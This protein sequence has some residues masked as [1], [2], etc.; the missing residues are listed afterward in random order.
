MQRANKVKTKKISSISLKNDL[1][2]N[3]DLYLLMLPYFL[4][5]FLMIVLAMVSSIILSFTY[6]NMFETPT[7]VGISNYT[8]LLIDDE[9][10][11][12]ALKNTI[13]FAVI[14]GPISYI[15]CFFMAWFI[16][17]FG[18]KSRVFLTFIFY[19]PSLSSS[20]FFI[21]QFIFSGDA[22]GFINGQLMAFGLINDPI[23]WLS[24][25]KYNLIILM[26][27]QIWMSLGAGF[28]AF[29]AG[30]NMIDNSLYEAGMIDGIRN[31]FQELF[32]ITLPMV[33]PQLVFSA[34]MQIAISFSVSTISMQL[35]GFPSTNYSAH[36]IV[37][38][39]M[40]Y[41]MIRYEMGYACAIAV[42]LF[43]LTILFKKALDLG[44]RYVKSDD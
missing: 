40:D 8:S 36:T 2:K 1:I 27:I 35:C 37:L 12:I 25:P 19:A 28:L 26:V 41:A 32:Y 4:L 15:L 13:A 21:W 42:A 23:Q 39:L 33:K 34:V 18:A 6:Y 43:V 10:F 3:K 14:T 20:V 9:V 16:N 17:E 7:F 24:D 31:R 5:F 29:I 30:F 11:Y 38:H 44:L 22:Y